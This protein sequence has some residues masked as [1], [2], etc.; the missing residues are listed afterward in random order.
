STARTLTTLYPGC[1]NTCA[2]QVVVPLACWL[3][4]SFTCTS[5]WSIPRLSLATPV[6]STGGDIKR[7][8]LGGASTM[9]TDGATVSGSELVPLLVGGGTSETGAELTALSA[10][11]ALTR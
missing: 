2:A 9:A 10:R 1:S 6:N 8:P 3:G 7:A 11:K 5:T 4:P